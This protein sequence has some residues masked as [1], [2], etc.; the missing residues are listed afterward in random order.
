MDLAEIIKIN[1]LV[2]NRIDFVSF[3]DWYDHRSPAERHAL[4][5]TLLVFAFQAGVEEETWEQAIIAGQL[6]RQ[7]ALIEHLKSFH[8]TDLALHDW[9]GFFEWLGRL[10]ERDKY[11]VFAIAVYLFGSA[12][13]A[14]F[15]NEM[16]EHC[17]HWWH[18]D[19]LDQRVVDDVL[20]DAEFYRTSMKDDERIQK[21]NQ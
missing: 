9:D 21:T 15:R 14:V 4:I 12:E 19:L 1:Q 16:K 17:N 20:G 2:R 3:K 13:G 6:Q 8:N 5:S 11:D 7:A 18:R 10:A